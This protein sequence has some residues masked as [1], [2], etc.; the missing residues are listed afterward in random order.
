MNHK[1]MIV[2]GEASGDLHASGLVREIQ[3]AAP[4]T[5]IYGIG[6][7]RM[8]DLGVTLYYHIFEMSVLGFVDVLKQI[9]FFKKVYRELVAVMENDQPNLLI[10]IDYPGLNLKLAKAAQERGIKVLYY[11]APQV[12]AWGAGRV[13]KMARWVDK[14]AVI[15]PFEEKLYRDAGIDATFVGHPLLEVVKASL[16][17]DEF[18][19]QQ[20]IET[21]Q[22]TIGLL[23][24]SRHL[25]VKRLLPEMLLAVEKL[26]ADYPDIQ[27]IIGQADTVDE[28]VY[29][30]ILGSDSSVKL[31]KK[32][33]YNIMKH[34]D[35]LIVA[36]GTATLESAL[37]ATPLLIVYK[38][39]PV[40]YFIGRQLVK[41]DSIGLVNVIAEKKIVPEFIQGELKA[42]NLAPELK[43]LLFEE[44]ARKQMI[45]DI[46]KI[47]EKLGEPGAS[48]RTAKMAVD[49]MAS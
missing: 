1:V 10:L 25:E 4:G 38:V 12:W 34:S 5:E 3:I 11:I 28:S 48:I 8:R 17:K 43:R 26:R 46:E 15:I 20:G 6:G 35:V 30:H 18:F 13:K 14:M 19:A 16:G 42:S 36:S 49:L 27:A 44:N 22:K 33:T 23:P 45:R 21:T 24:G 9:R 31:V 32:N 47:R 7:D 37:F 41:I 39:D 2:A 40:S 29:S